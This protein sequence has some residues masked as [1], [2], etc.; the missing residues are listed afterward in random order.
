MDA[1]FASFFQNRQLRRKQWFSG[2]KKMLCYIQIG[3]FWAKIKRWMS[4]FDYNSNTTPWCYVRGKKVVNQ[5]ILILYNYKLNQVSFILSPL[6][7]GNF[8]NQKLFSTLLF[9]LI[10]KSKTQFGSKEQY[11]QFDNVNDL[12]QIQNT[13]YIT[14]FIASIYLCK[15]EVLQKHDKKKTNIYT[16]IFSGVQKIGQAKIA[17]SKILPIVDL[18]PI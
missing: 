10:H 16:K 6:L 7:V 1:T 2:P 8:Q 3:L 18:L 5:Q 4:K 12:Q 17:Q 13:K 9:G 15:I 14:I 11:Q